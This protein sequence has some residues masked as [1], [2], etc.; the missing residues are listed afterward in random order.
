[1]AIRDVQEFAHLTDEELETFG[2]ELD[3]LRVTIEKSLGDADAAYIRRIIK[4]HRALAAAGRITLFASSFPPAWVAGT[5]FLATA[6][7][8]E[9]MELGHNVMHG[10]WDWMN[11]PE[12][13]STSWEWDNVCSGDQWRHSHNYIHHRYTNVLGKDWDIGYGILRMTRDQKWNPAYLGQ[14]IYNLFLALLFEWGVGVHDIQGS[15][16]MEHTDLSTTRTKLKQFGKK[17]ARQM[18]KDYVVYPALSGPQWLST[19]T[20]NATANLIR[21]LWSYMIIFCGHFPDGVQHFTLEELEGETQAEWYLR[22]LYGAANFT[23][24]RTLHVLSG[25][26]GYQIEHHIFPDLPS[27]RFPQIQVKIQELCRRFDLP[28]N[29]N[30]LPHQYGTVLRTIFRLALPNRPET[31]PE[32]QAA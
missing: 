17:I 28:Y 22:Q 32:P 8:I 19:L 10:Q 7:I 2:H 14:P 26:L 13:H 5:A 6:K 18:A 3:Q 23:G 16:L 24:G 15:I 25:S 29:I 31:V 9:N 1:M 21:N 12:I 20:A 11:D 4:I 27:N 30:T